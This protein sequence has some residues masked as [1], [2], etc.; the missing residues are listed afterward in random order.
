MPTK[1]ILIRHGETPWNAEKRYCGF[2]DIGISAKGR[3]QAIHLKK[4]LNGYDIYGVY[5]SD[6]KRAIQTAKI[7]FTGMQIKKIADL[8]EMHFGVFEGLT[9]REIMK[10]YPKIYSAWLKNPF[11]AVIPEGESLI[12][13]RKRVSRALKKIIS[14]NK[15]KTIVVVCHGGSI[16]AFITGVLKSNDFWKYIPHAVSISIIEE[17]NNT[18]KLRVFDDIAHLRRGVPCQKLPLF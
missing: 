5:S 3:K 7:I 10:K 14:T 15:N 2:K 1:L 4:R 16:S 18:L 17:K 9:Y 6:K 12:S 11:T 13:F 8:K